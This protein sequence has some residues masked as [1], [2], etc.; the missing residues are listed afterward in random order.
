MK[1]SVDRSRLQA[2]LLQKQV[3]ER[4]RARHLAVAE[5]LRDKEFSSKIVTYARMQVGKWRIN[6]LC[7]DD[8]IKEWSALLSD[9]E[10]AAQVL[11]S[12][13]PRAVSLRQNSPFAAY[14]R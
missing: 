3:D 2:R 5:M 13:S 11:E 6:H 9:P 1:L 10:R 14:L 12:D 4:R 7:S 8:Y